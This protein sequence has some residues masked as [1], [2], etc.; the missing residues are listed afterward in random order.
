VALIKQLHDLG[1]KCSTNITAVIRDDDG[2]D[3]MGRPDPYTV[4][5]LGFQ[6]PPGVVFLRDPKN[7]NDFFKGA[8]DY[9]QNGAQSDV[10]CNP[11]YDLDTRGFYPDLT[12]PVAQQW[13]ISN[14][15]YLLETVQIDMI[16]QDETCP[17]L[18]EP[19]PPSMS[20][21]AQVGPNPTSG[22]NFHT[23]PPDVVQFDYGRNQQHVRI[24]NAYAHTMLRGTTAALSQLRPEKRGFIIARGGYAGLQR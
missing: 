14:Y 18:A 19:S 1:F 4:R 20:C 3:A 21:P 16:W 11:E 15:K 22:E 2:K 23:L 7:P 8:V 6:N 9:G 24:H 17:G 13:W 5:D 12:L 10:P